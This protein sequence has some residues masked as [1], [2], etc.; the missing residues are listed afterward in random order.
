MQ[1]EGRQ[2]AIRGSAVHNHNPTMKIY[3]VIFPLPQQH[4]SEV[5]LVT[6]KSIHLQLWPF[7]T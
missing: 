7:C 2:K 3:W 4:Q 1:T 5:V 6:L